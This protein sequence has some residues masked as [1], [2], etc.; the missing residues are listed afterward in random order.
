MA[1]TAEAAVVAPPV[2]GLSVDTLYVVVVV[3][4]G[5]VASIGHA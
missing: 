3:A 5:A 1:T 2:A 4:V